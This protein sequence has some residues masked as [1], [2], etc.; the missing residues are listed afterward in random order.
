[1]YAGEDLLMLSGVQHFAFCQRQWGLIHLEQQ[2]QSNSLTLEGDY[3]HERADNPGCITALRGV[4]TLRAVPL[5]SYQ[6]GLRGISDIVELHKTAD[7]TNVVFIPKYNDYFL[8]M[9]VEYKHGKPKE[10]PEDRVQLCAQV[11]SMEEMYGIS[12]QKGA[13]YYASTRHR[14]EIFIDEELRNLTAELCRKMHALFISGRCPQGQYAPKCKN[15]SLM[16]RCMPKMK[17][18]YKD[19]KNYLKDLF[20]A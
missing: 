14:E 11:M 10:S 1:M 15:C 13:L 6:L 2:W 16:E 19:V 4:I 12:L 17:D 9:P 7:S 8:P 5:V 20:D 18:R 3:L